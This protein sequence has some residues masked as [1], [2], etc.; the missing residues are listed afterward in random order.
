M[1]F[2]AFLI[3]NVYKTDWWWQT[4]V[5][6]DLI[7]LMVISSRM[8]GGSLNMANYGNGGVD[9]EDFGLLLLML[10]AR[11]ESSYGRNLDDS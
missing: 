7:Y 4:F 10:P 1:H 8:L 5:D 2:Q 11:F 6:D 3:G 9:F